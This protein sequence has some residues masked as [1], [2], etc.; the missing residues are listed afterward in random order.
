MYENI[1]SR[2]PD[3]VYISPQGLGQASVATERLVPSTEVNGIFPV[4]RFN[5]EYDK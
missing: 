5:D 3:L 2:L 1:C 4:W